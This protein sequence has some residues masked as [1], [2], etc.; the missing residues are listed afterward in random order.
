MRAGGNPSWNTGVDYRE[1]LERSINRDEVK[2]LYKQAGLNLDEDL[3][4]LQNA[5]RIAAVPSAVDYLKS[6]IVFNGQIDQPV[7]TMHTTGDGLVLNQDEQ[8]YASV[9][10]AA[11]NEERLRQTFIHRAG[12]CTFTPAEVVA[13]F[14]TMV[15]RLDTGRWGDTT[16]PRN[17]NMTA[18][19]TGLGPSD[20]IRFKPSAFLRP[21]DARSVRED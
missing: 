18:A 20:F 21:F 16:S 13:A 1:Q 15:R 12:H 11:G 7:L 17:M 10:R 3:E 5:P 2:A 6:F 8:A 14:K 4:T 19:S 9:V